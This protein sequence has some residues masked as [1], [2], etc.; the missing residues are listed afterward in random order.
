[1]SIMSRSRMKN[2]F[3]VVVVA[4]CLRPTFMILWRGYQAWWGLKTTTHSYS[5]MWDQMRLQQETPKYKKGL[6]FPQK[7]IK[8]IR[9]SSSVLLHPPRSKKKETDRP[10]EWWLHGWC[11]VQGFRFYD[12]DVL[13]I[14][15]VCWHPM[16]C[17]LPGGAR[18]FWAAG[19]LSLL[20]GH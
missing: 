17:T 13:L 16:G 6:Y 5:F 9:S 2:S 3:F 18:V 15:Q 4:T 8:E 20:V 11:H 12:L 1:M 19:W 7:D 10:S 14:D